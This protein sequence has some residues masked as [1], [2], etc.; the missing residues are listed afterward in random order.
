MGIINFISEQLEKNVDNPKGV[1]YI[2]RAVNSLPKG[3]IKSC[4]GV[5]NALLNK[6]SNVMPELH[7][8]GYNYCEPLTKLDKR[9]AR[10]DEPVNKLDAGP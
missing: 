8:P 2:I 5:L 9:L 6:L 7:L 4:S 3:F 10:G 1:D